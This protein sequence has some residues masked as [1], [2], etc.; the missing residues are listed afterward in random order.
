MIHAHERLEKGIEM[1]FDDNFCLRKCV[2]HCS[3]SLWH[4]FP[5]LQFKN[6]QPFGQITN[7]VMSRFGPYEGTT[8]K[9]RIISLSSCSSR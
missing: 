3:S 1:S 9:G 6:R 8:W 4:H 2:C 5:I 7:N